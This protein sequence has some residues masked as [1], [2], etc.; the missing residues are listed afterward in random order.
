MKFYDKKDWDLTGKKFGQLLVLRVAEFQEIKISPR[1]GRHWLV[2]CDCGKELVRQGISFKYK[3]GQSCGHTKHGPAANRLA[4]GEAAKNAAYQSMKMHP[5]KNRRKAGKP[6]V[7]ELTRDEFIAITSKPCTYCGI[8]WS[9][10]IGNR[11]NK[12]STHGSYKYNGIDRIDSSK[13]YI[14]G[15]CTPCCKACNFAKNAQSSE[16]FRSH[17]ARMY[18]HFVLEKHYALS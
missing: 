7:W 10:E 1:P 5:L 12:K 2:R 4:F 18:N 6:L 17:I 9:K 8:P 16:E 3:M 13:G 11:K 14:L 15:N